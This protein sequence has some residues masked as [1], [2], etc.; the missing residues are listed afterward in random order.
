MN[1]VAKFN[2]VV[3]P[4]SQQDL[5]F[6]ELRKIV[7][8]RACA[9]LRAELAKWIRDPRITAVHKLVA[10]GKLIN[11]RTKIEGGYDAQKTAAML[12]GHSSVLKRIEYFRDYS[13]RSFSTGVA[14][15]FEVAYSR[16]PVGGF[17]DWHTDH[18]LAPPHKGEN[19][20]IEGVRRRVLNF[21]L[22][23]TEG[24]GGNLELCGDNQVGGGTIRVG[25]E[26]VCE[27][28]IGKFILFPSYY[29]HRVTKTTGIRE[30]LHG[31][32][33]VGFEG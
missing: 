7:T 19:L 17:Y 2:P 10:N 22:F 4:K 3:E 29:A 9:V 27:P 16:Y 6:V 21:V 12:L 30:C 26:Y 33:C 25:P 13:F 18:H 1:Q 11:N 32:V 14:N 31:H 28:E 15:K 23:L 20:V 8:T 24:T 5:L